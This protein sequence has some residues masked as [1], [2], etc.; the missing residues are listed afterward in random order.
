MLKNITSRESGND[1]GKLQ[2]LG[3]TEKETCT[4][5]AVTALD[6]SR[7]G[8]SKMRVGRQTEGKVKG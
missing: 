6:A 1:I 5:V 7:R 3:V 8:E 4:E 2:C